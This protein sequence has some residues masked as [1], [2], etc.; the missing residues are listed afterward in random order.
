[1]ISVYGK[2]HPYIKNTS[3]IYI[4]RE[5]S[6]LLCPVFGVQFIIEGTLSIPGTFF[7]SGSRCQGRLA[8]PLRIV[9]WTS[10]RPGRDRCLCAGKDRC[11]G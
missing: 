5:V 7:R 6:L 11:K 2:P 1:M 9:K 8:G 4:V 10:R 3:R